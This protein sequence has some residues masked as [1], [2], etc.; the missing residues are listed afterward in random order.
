MANDFLSQILGHVLTGTGAGAAGAE[1]GAGAQQQNPRL[2]TIGSM[3]SLGD[4]LGGLM[5]GSAGTAGGLGGFGSGGSSLGGLGGGKGALVAMLLP[6]AMQWVKRSGGVSSVL[7][8]FQQKGYSQQAASWVSTGE[9]ESIAPQAINQV[10]GSDEL[11]RLSQQLGMG[12]SADDVASGM[13]HILPQ[14]VSHLTP[15]GEVPLDADNRL[16]NGISNLDQLMSQVK[17]H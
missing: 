6:M 15:Q 17:N 14:V 12:V 5:G 10:V 4:L 1:A 3:G 9:N 13:A 7:D 16:D 8:R 2:D 11:S